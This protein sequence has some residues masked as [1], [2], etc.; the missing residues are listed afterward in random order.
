MVH[1]QGEIVDSIEQ[2]IESTTV[3]VSIHEP[4]DF[5]PSSDLRG[6]AVI[7]LPI[8]TVTAHFR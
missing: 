1:E 7:F 8:H 6:D 4:S 5:D 2:N 3:Q